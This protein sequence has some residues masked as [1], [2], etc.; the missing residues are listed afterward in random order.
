M[1]RGGRVAVCSLCLLLVF[2]FVADVVDVSFLVV[3]VGWL[4][5]VCWLLLMRFIVKLCPTEQ[6]RC[7][8]S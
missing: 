7:G 2:V 8:Q 1:I 3:L 6:F 4:M 5:L